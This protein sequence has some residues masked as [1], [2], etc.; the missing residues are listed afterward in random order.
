GGTSNHF[1]TQALRAA[2]GWDAWNVTEDADLG[3]RLAR[4]GYRTADLP[5]STL[6]EAPITLRAWMNQRTRWMKGYLQ[7]CITH[8][9]HPASTLAQL[10]AWRFFGALV[11]T[12]GVVLSGLG[13]PLFVG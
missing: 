2:C 9:R 10:G 5:S 12:A 6:E 13:Y 4:L 8:S 1:R 7:T 11:V 3:I